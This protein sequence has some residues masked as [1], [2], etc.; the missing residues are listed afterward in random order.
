M[1]QLRQLLE[2]LD[3]TPLERERAGSVL[4]AD[5]GDVARALTLLFDLTSELE[6]NPIER[7]RLKRIRSFSTNT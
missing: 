3:L 6:L 1:D 5:G 2:D 7:A 4:D